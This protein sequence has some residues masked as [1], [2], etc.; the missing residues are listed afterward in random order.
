LSDPKAVATVNRKFWPKLKWAFLF[1][2]GMTQA[3]AEIWRFAVIGDTPYSANERAELPKMLEAIAD[4][5]V[6]FVAHIGDIKSGGDRCDDSL[7]EDRHRLFNASRVPFVYVPGDNEWS[8]CDRISN[9]S[10]DPLER[11]NKLR[12]LFMSDGLS[13]GQKKLPLEHQPGNYPEH[14]RFRLGP[15][16][17]VTLNLPGGNNNWG[18]TSQASSEFL[19]RNPVVLSWLKENFALARRDKLAG[20]VFL[21]QADPSFKHFSQGLAH[22]GYQDFLELLRDE[23]AQFAGQVVAVHG[24]TH[25]SR[26]DHPLRDKQGRPLNN[27][28]RVETFGYPLMGW[29]RGVIDTESPALFRFET[30]PW[31]PKLP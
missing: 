2:A 17:F 5:H 18:M 22:H 16:L 1:I 23:T 9:G 28:V 7:F 8:D 26:I 13:L 11:L 31:P 3:H 14:T 19:T 4:S 25:F 24:D 20:I 27:F 29:T 21:F 15:V 6:E 30:N 12:S 10:Y